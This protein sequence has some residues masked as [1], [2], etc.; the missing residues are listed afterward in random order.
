M[1]F[2]IAEHQS[3]PLV[4]PDWLLDSRRESSTDS[5]S[6]TSTSTYVIIAVVVILLL[7]CAGGGVWYYLC[8]SRRVLLAVHSHSLTQHV[9]LHSHTQKKNKAH[10]DKHEKGA[11]SDAEHSDEE[12]LVGDGKNGHPDSETDPSEDEGRAPAS[13]KRGAA[14]K[15]PQSETDSEPSGDERAPSSRR[16]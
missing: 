8:A 12:A 1:S 9:H 16:R 11:H 7:A 15:A 2:A 3:K 10:H 4:D 14:R 6:E 13:G 5:E